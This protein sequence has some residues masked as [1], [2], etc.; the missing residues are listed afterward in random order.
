MTQNATTVRTL[1]AVMVNNREQLM[2]GNVRDCLP[3]G[4][5]HS[6]ADADHF[7]V[8]V[9]PTLDEQAQFE[10]KNRDWRHISEVLYELLPKD[11]NSKDSDE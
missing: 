11:L 10:F 1:Q 2:K 3:I 4:I 7:I 9:R 8:A 6:R 5:F